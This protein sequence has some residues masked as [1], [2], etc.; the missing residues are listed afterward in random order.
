MHKHKILVVEDE[1][2][3]AL[4][5]KMSLLDAGYDVPHV[6]RS[7]DEA[8]NLAE[9]H[10]PD[11]ILMDVQLLGDRDGIDAACAIVANRELPVIFLTGNA[12]LLEDPRLAVVPRFDVLTKPPSDDELLLSIRKRLEAPLPA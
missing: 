4:N 9:R 8:E 6:A 10:R 11:L 2:I 7:A 12:H 3:I 1:S 5:L